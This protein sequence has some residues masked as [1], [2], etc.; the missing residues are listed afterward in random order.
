MRRQMGRGCR[1]VLR[2]FRRYQTASFTVSRKALH[3]R[4]LVGHPIQFWICLH[5]KL[6][7]SVCT[8][9]GEKN[10][11]GHRQ[12]QHGNYALSFAEQTRLHSVCYSGPR[13]VSPVFCFA[14]RI[15]VANGHSGGAARFP[16]SYCDN[17]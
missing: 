15:Y 16:T 6:F 17:I 3:G 12:A 2:I 8:V 4:D 11:I 5:L 7:L 13:W 9:V 10:L 14:K 1:I